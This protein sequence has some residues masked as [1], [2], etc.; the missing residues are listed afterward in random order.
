MPGSWGHGLRH[1]HITDVLA[2]LVDPKRGPDQDDRRGLSFSSGLD[3]AG[4]RTVGRECSHAHAHRDD[5]IGTHV[6]EPV[7]VNHAPG[8]CGEAKAKLLR[9][10]LEL[11]VLRG[12][13]CHTHDVS[14][15]SARL[16]I[17][18]RC[19]QPAT[20][21]RV[22]DNR[23]GLLPSLCLGAESLLENLA[24]IQWHGGAAS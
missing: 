9:R 19:V 7:V 14:G 18:L 22:T 15:D 20:Q 17:G 2:C 16:A 3:T 10:A 4:S 1:D 12:R 23:D 24:R 13:R 5:T 11:L 8:L 6:A 21:D